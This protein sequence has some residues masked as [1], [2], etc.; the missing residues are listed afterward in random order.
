MTVQQGVGRK[1]IWKVY[2]YTGQDWRIRQKKLR[3]ATGTMNVNVSQKVSVML[4]R[5][6]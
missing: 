4:A 6:M 1:P 5:Y 3:L 2:I